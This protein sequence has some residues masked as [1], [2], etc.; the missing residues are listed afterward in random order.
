MGRTTTGRVALAALFLA[1][2]AAGAQAIAR[3][4]DS[5]LV[6]RAMQFPSPRAA[7]W[8]AVGATVL[9]MAAGASLPS[10]TQ[11]GSG[12]ALWVT[13]VLAGPMIG[14]WYG[15]TLSTSWSGAL[16]RTGGLAIAAAGASGCGGGTR[17]L[18]GCSAGEETAML[19]G[20]VL[21][22]GSAVYE[23]ITVGAR[24]REHN[25]AEARAMVLPLFSP[26]MR[27]VGVEVVVGF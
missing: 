25:D 8:I 24:V 6:A 5:A 3:P 26:S 27:S 10:R 13:G 1:A 19:G 9:P 21:A 18:S 12:T 22:V 15:G 20:A 2:Q 23:I 4:R 11:G 17:S 7:T 16:L 14:D